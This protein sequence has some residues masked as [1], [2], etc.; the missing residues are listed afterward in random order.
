MDMRADAK[1]IYTRAI[2]AAL[3]DNA[4]RVALKDIELQGNIYVAAVG[5]AAWQMGKT[6]SE[7]LGSRIK[8]GIVITKHGY[9]KGAI[10]R[11]EVYEAGHP[12]PDDDSYAATEKVLELVKPLGEGD[13]VLFLLSGGGSALFEKPLIPAEDMSRLTQELLA[14]GADINEINTLRKRFSAVKGGKFALACMPAKVYN[15]VLSDVMV[16]RID[17]IASGPAAPD[18]TTAEQAKY[19]VEKY[20]ITMTEQMRSL[21]ENETPKSI[22]NVETKVI[23]SVNQLCRSAAKTC[24]ELGYEPVILT[25]SLSCTAKD[26]GVFLSNIAQQ[27]AGDAKKRAFIAGGETVVHI[28][29]S[30]LG[31][32]NQELALAAAE[33]IAG[34]PNV[35]VFSV[36]SDGTDGPTDAAGGYVDGSTKQLLEEKGISIFRT[37]QSNDSYHAL[38]ACGGLIRTGATGTNVNDLSVLLIG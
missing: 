12:V 9:G 1:L 11:L 37:L 32:R 33:N 36:G 7:V 30:G 5:K 10:E 34:M 19:I 27:Y 20:G 13:T 24:A 16:D 4:V 28:T 15:I 38:D 26:A 29:G 8:A 6:V 17:S 2:D 22:S 25:S 21:I 35:C 23:G 18:G 14:S 3:P 31:G